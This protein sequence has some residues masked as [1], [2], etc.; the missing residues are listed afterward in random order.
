MRFVLGRAHVLFNCIQDWFCKMSRRSERAM[1]ARL[2][3]FE[4]LEPRLLLSTDSVTAQPTVP[5]ELSQPSQAVVVDLTP[6]VPQHEGSQQATPAID[7][8]ASGRMCGGDVLPGLRLVNP[9]SANLSQQL[10]YLSFGG[11]AGVVYDGPVTVGPLD[12]PAFCAPGGLVGQEQQ[13]I[14]RIVIGLQKIFA[15]SGVVFTTTRPSA[16]QACSTIYIGGDGSVF[17]QYGSFLGLAERVDVGNVDAQDE[18]FVFSAQLAPT[19]QDLDQY[20]ATLARLIAHEA[21]HLLGYEHQTEATREEGLARCA[22]LIIDH[23]CADVRPIPEAALATAKATLHVG[24]G[25]TSHGSQLTNGWE[26]DGMTALNNFANNGGLGLTLPENPFS[27]SHGG[28]DGVLD[29]CHNSSHLGALDLGNPDFTTWAEGTRTFLVTHPNTNVILWSWCGEVSTATEADINTY[30]SLMS[31][32]EV[33]YPNV[34]FVYMTGHLDGTGVSGNLNVRNE[35]IRQ[36]CRT[37]DKILYDFADIESY[38]PDGLV[39]YLPLNANANCDYDSDGDGTLDRNWAI[40]WQNSHTVGV[41]WYVCDSAHSQPLNANRKAYAFWW[42]L[43][44]LAGWN[45]A[46]ESNTAPV[47]AAI[48][49]KSTN[50]GQ[51]LSFTASATDSD[52]AA[53]TLTFSLMNAPTG[54]SIN[55]SSGLFNWT[56]TEGQGPGSY[57]LTVRVTDNGTPNLYDEEAITITVSEVNAAPVL[58]AIGDKIVNEGELLSFTASATDS[59]IPANTLTFSLLNAPTGAS[60]NASTGV[61]NWTPAEGQGPGSYNLTVRVTDNGTPNLYDEEAITVTV[62]VNQPNTAPV[63]AAI[64]DKSVNEGQL[65]SF[66]ASATDSD[67]PANT[68]AF[69]LLNAPAGASIDASSG[70]FNWT[71]AEG[72][73]PGDYNMTVRVTDNGTPS[74]YDEETITVTVLQI[75]GS[76]VYRFCLAADNSQHFY[77]IK[78]AERDKL[79]NNYS[80]VWLYEGVAYHAFTDDSQLDVAPVYRFWSGSAHFYT[81]NTAECDKLVNNYA[82][83]WTYEGV[84]FYAYAEGSQPVGTRAVY[85]FWAGTTNVHFFTVSQTERD[86]LVNVYSNVWTDEGIAWYAYDPE[87]L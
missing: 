17:S 80:Q 38:D 50:E 77:T 51:L 15:N 28:G 18:A 62:T 23:T 84:A 78:A 7:L 73:G 64:G 10:I 66:T 37:H 44:R 74:L 48:G 72:Q 75:P 65:L 36:Y 4:P 33:D 60:I 22:A 40:D 59:D 55:A 86:K 2:S 83:V 29:F 87:T 30:L 63:L 12:I 32:L 79:I 34:Q 58:A 45:P 43:A 6:A 24:Y 52:V 19:S 13:I 47:L 9:S 68:L 16:D 3:P 61:F 57:N 11:A 14:A 53:N 25:H 76:P 26:A 82:N 27:Y 31:Q 1:P 39:N 41:D 70:V 54:A 67:T 69:S 20:A 21:G 35:Q 42:T 8:A 56:A 81:M 85:R 46:G 49:N 71:P 5:L